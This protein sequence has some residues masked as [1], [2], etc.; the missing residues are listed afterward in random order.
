ML[1]H[2]SFSVVCKHKIGLWLILSC[3]LASHLFAGVGS[4]LFKLGTQTRGIFRFCEEMVVQKNPIWKHMAKAWKLEH[5]GTI[6]TKRYGLT[7][8]YIWR[9]DKYIF[10]CFF[11]FICEGKQWLL[12]RFEKYIIYVL[13]V[14]SLLTVSF[15]IV[16]LHICTIDAFVSNSPGLNLGRVYW[17]IDK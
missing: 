16:Q 11:F 4:L 2:V 8:F 3:A 13:M 10:G 14:N 12:D 7:V 15:D 1:S 6:K 9:M 5:S 17:W